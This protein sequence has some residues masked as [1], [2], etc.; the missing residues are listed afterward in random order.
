MFYVIGLG[1]SGVKANGFAFTLVSTTIGDVD[2]P[3]SG[4]RS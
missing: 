2:E 1:N 3:M 4:V